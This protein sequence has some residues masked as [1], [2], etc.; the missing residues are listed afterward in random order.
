MAKMISFAPDHIAKLLRKGLLVTEN[1]FKKDDTIKSI[2]NSI[3]KRY[4]FIPNHIFQAYSN[5]LGIL[6]AEGDL[7]SLEK[8]QKIVDA[9]TSF[10]SQNIGH[11][12][13]L[14]FPRSAISM[15]DKLSILCAEQALSD[16]LY[17]ATMDPQVYLLTF[18]EMIDA[19]NNFLYFKK[20]NNQKQIV[21]STVLNDNIVLT[22]K[23]KI[24]LFQL[25]KNVAQYKENILEYLNE[26]D[27]KK[28]KLDYEEI[29]FCLNTDEE[30]S[31]LDQ[32]INK[33]INFTFAKNQ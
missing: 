25:E 3:K 28:D 1:D 15:K 13:L 32:Y 14:T 9:N 16:I 17:K 4:S 12:Q 10:S 8:I 7:A 23:Q 33:R 29:L 24:N 31:F 30:K 22:L 2:I 21:Q 20:A 18:E 26:I 11:S 19:M 6:L 27:F 5:G